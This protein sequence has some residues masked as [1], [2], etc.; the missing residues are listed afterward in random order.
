MILEHQPSCRCCLL[1]LQLLEGLNT[2]SGLL[3]QLVV[4]H[5]CLVNAASHDVKRWT[6]H[7]TY[8][9]C[10]EAYVTKHKHVYVI[11]IYIARICCQEVY[12]KK[13][14]LTRFQVN[15][16]HRSHSMH[17]GCKAA[18]LRVLEGQHQCCKGPSWTADGTSLSY[19][20][21]KETPCFFCTGWPPRTGWYSYIYI[22]YI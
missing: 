21:L 20:H 8:G 1:W 4:V 13:T 9:C 16:G 15:S 7:V 18:M 6:F 14:M 19:H 17:E 2:T 22:G 3:D 10:M 12:R 5:G 11:Y